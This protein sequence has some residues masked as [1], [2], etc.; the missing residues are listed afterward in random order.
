[1]A[2][3]AQRTRPMSGAGS[4]I[5]GQSQTLAQAAFEGPAT[6]GERDQF[7]PE[8]AESKEQEPQRPPPFAD[9]PCAQQQHPP[10]FKPNG[11]FQALRDGGKLADKEFTLSA[12][13][14]AIRS[15]GREKHY[16]LPGYTGFIRGMQ[17]ISG[18]TYGEATR[19][20]Y[21]TDYR[22]HASTSPVP[23]DPNRNRKIPHVNPPNSFATHVHGDK[24]YN[25]PGYTGFVPG[26][27]HTYAKTYGSATSEEM[28]KSSIRNP[29]PSPKEREGF[30]YTARPRQR[31]VLDS[32]PLPGQVATNTAPGK[33]IPAHL[34]SLRYFPI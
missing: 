14:A 18:R 25:L 11:S 19:R 28:Y 34:N 7:R 27:R 10:M 30:A 12:Q 15:Q 13:Q 26:V 22:E 31:L 1:M 17:H 21:D 16:S 2:E 33:L 32:S 23:S 9:W 3:F 6:V 29:R 4:R 8:L 5:A 24:V 20:A